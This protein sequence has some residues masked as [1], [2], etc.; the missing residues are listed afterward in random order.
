MAIIT[1]FKNYFFASCRICILLFFLI[2]SNYVS[3]AQDQPGLSGFVQLSGSYFNFRTNTISSFMKNKVSETITN[4]LYEK[5]QNQQLFSSLGASELRYTFSKR[6][7]QIYFGGSLLDIVRMDLVQQLA[8]R[9]LLANNE[10]ISIGVLGTTVPVSVWED[11]YAIG[12]ERTGTSRQSIGLRFEWSNI[13]NSNV[14]FQYDLRGVNIDEKSGS[15]LDLSP[16]EMSLLNR[17]GT[18]HRLK[19]S[20]L[21]RVGKEHI[22]IPALIFSYTNT[23]GEAKRGYGIRL[24]ASHAYTKKRITIASN[25]EGGLRKYKAS[26]PIY[27]KKQT[28]VEFGFTESVFY[29]LNNNPKAVLLLNGSLTY[30]S[31]QSNIDFHSQSGFLVQLGLVFRFGPILTP[32]GRNESKLN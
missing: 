4:S 7:Y 24:E 20:Y 11:P 27:D 26:N 15:T 3:K 22:I 29:R 13:L 16:E 31:S 2:G 25:I 1:F 6:K 10:F 5:P 14:A 23:K 32:P 21:K 9:R 12:V 17:N 19:T 8:I 30:L 28:N 18:M